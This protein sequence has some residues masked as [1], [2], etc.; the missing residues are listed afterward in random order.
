MAHPNSKKVCDPRADAKVPKTSNLPIGKRASTL[1]K[2]ANQPTEA[3]VR[4]AEIMKKARGHAIASQ[5]AANDLA[6]MNQVTVEGLGPEPDIFDK[7]VNNPDYPNE[8]L[9]DPNEAMETEDFLMPED[10]VAKA[11]RTNDPYVNVT[12]LPSPPTTHLFL[13]PATQYRAPQRATC[14]LNNNNSNRWTLG[15]YLLSRLTLT[16]HSTWLATPVKSNKPKKRSWNL[17]T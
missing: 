5:V 3:Q 9:I 10:P 6:L 4:Q 13:D 17:N 8:Q 12:V 14:S 11:I 16:K 2:T 7:I 1:P 15:S